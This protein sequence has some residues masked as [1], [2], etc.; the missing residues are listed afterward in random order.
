M[1]KK[2]KDKSEYMPSADIILD[3]I[4]EEQSAEDKIIEFYGAY[5]RTAS[6]I[7]MTSPVVGDLGYKFDEDLAQEIRKEIVGC[8]PALKRIIKNKIS[9]EQKVI[10]IV[11]L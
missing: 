8:L 4:N 5:I 9:E 7:Q 2:K 3:L 11:N 6:T 10:L 1:K